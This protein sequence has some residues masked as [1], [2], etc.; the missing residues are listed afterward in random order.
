MAAGGNLGISDVNSDRYGYS[1]KVGDISGQMNEK[2]NLE[3]KSKD[4]QELDEPETPS[5]PPGLDLMGRDFVG[6]LQA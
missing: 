3:S 1:F 2:G 6:R 5:P 4:D